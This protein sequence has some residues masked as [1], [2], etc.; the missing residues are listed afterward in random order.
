MPTS[1]DGWANP[2]YEPKRPYRF[3]VPFPIF[4]PKGTG[5]ISEIF[6]VAGNLRSPKRS[7]FGKD[8]YFPMFCTSVTKPQITTE[9]FRIKDPASGVFVIRGEQPTV[10]DF[11]PV[12]IELLDTYSHDIEASLMAM[13][14]AYGQLATPQ[15]GKADDP[16]RQ[17]A[18]KLIPIRN[19]DG[20]GDN[21]FEIIE[22]LDQSR[23]TTAGE[24]PFVSV[25]IMENQG[26]R[27]P[28]ARKIL[29]YNPYIAGITLGTLSYKETDFSTVKVQIVYDSADYEYYAHRANETGLDVEL[30]RTDY[31]LNK[32]L[33]ETRRARLLTNEQAAKIGAAGIHREA[34]LEGKTIGEV[35]AERRAAATAAERAEFDR[36]QAIQDM[37]PA[38]RAN[39]Q[40]LAQA[41][42]ADPA[43]I[44]AMTPAERAQAADDWNASQGNFEAQQRADEQS[45]RAANRAALHPPR[46]DLQS[47]D[48][49]TKRIRQESESGG[50][51]VDEE[52]EPTP[53]EEE[54]WMN[55]GNPF[56]R[57][58]P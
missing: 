1:F 56:P 12:E 49:E 51:W 45:E 29:L 4:L 8:C 33:E 27:S 25:D 44:A 5:K 9:A 19:R 26:K 10:F 50:G 39:A 42:G 14:Y 20:T 57:G 21:V 22:L 35:T 37:S 54:D 6:G 55:E 31:V 36:T 40:A 18:G 24:D 34:A 52:T 13:L 2:Y 16:R 53:V 58:T 23:Y 15:A 43:A 17:A 3:L 32:R 38:D 47:L 28:I 11:A 48:E 30:S 46:G 7:R 41:A